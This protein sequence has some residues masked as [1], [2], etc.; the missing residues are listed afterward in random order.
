MSDLVI[1]GYLACVD[2]TSEPRAIWVE[3]DL[4]VRLRVAHEPVPETD[5][6]DDML[7]RADFTAMS[8]KVYRE[9]EGVDALVSGYENVAITIN[10]AIPASLPRVWGKDGVGYNFRHVVPAAAFAANARHR[11]IY[12]FV[13]D[14][15]TTQHCVSVEVQGPTGDTASAGSGTVTGL[16]GL[17]GAGYA[18][19]SAT[20]VAIGTGSKTFATQTGLAYS[21]GARVRITSAANTANWM[22]GLV[23]AYSGNTLVVTV[24]VVSGSGTHADWNINLAGEP[25]TAGTEGSSYTFDVTRAPYS[26]TGDGTT[27]DTTAVQAALTAAAAIPGSVV[28]LPEGTYSVTGAVLT[29]TNVTLFGPGKLKL[30]ENSTTNACLRL[31]SAT[32]CRVVG[33]S[34]DGGRDS[35]HTGNANA[36]QIDATSQHNVLEDCYAT[37]TYLETGVTT[38]RGFEIQGSYNTL[39]RPRCYDCDRQ[40]IHIAK[41]VVG[42]QVFGMSVV[43]T[44]L[45]NGA[46]QGVRAVGNEGNASLF[47]GGII[48]QSAVSFDASASA[49]NC[50]LHDPDAPDIATSCTI[51]GLTVIGGNG[52]HG[53]PGSLVKFARCDEIFIQDLRTYSNNIVGEC[54]RFAEAIKRIHLKGLRLDTRIIKENAL[55]TDA[56]P[57]WF[58]A[59]D[60]HLGLHASAQP[61]LYGFE[62]LRAQRILIERCQVNGRYFALMDIEDDDLVEAVFDNNQLNGYGVD[63]LTNIFL[64]VED[65]ATMMKTSGKYVYLPNNR[66]ATLGTG[67]SYTGGTPGKRQLL[68]TVDKTGRIFEQAAI[69]VAT[70]VNWRIGDIIRNTTTPAVGVPEKWTCKVAGAGG[71]ANQFQASYTYGVLSINT[72]AVGNVGTGEDTLISYSLPANTLAANGDAVEIEAG[73]SFA[74]DTDTKRVKLYLDA[75]LLFDSGASG[76]QDGGMVI[77]VVVRRHSSTEAKATV[78]MLSNGGG[79]PFAAAFGDSLTIGPLSWS[80]ALTIMGTGESTDN[81]DVVMDSLLVRTVR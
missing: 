50:F 69:P 79:T 37:N 7:A 80:S 67:L 45:T 46:T 10:D 48:D 42:T 73:F 35:A 43:A 6:P 27:N 53:D 14:G 56:G 62:D 66:I 2:A 60:C 74:N 52:S 5:E 64:Q 11:V 68:T 21:A 30:R 76:H 25:G 3:S 61:T 16:P 47:V 38:G 1:R 58:H 59:E 75:S 81:N 57:E 71:T 77:R 24:A 22:E 72:T 55:D 54:L 31:S 49:N 65:A 4:V 8:Y 44:G 17:D 36:F 19:T 78:S 70:D 13:T 34:V 40:G 9:V 12:R 51:V 28:F 32:H 20:S 33:V 23:S 18:A 26:A 39:V 63:P 41:N 29:G 15:V